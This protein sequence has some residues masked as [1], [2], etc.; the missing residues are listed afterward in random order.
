[1]NSETGFDEQPGIFPRLL[2][3]TAILALAFG[4]Q[5]SRGIYSPDEGY[6]VSIAQAMAQTGD[7][8]IPRLHQVPWLDKPPLSL[9]GIATGLLVF[10]QN[11]WGARASHALC[12]TLTVM[13]VFVLGRTLGTRREGW[14]AATIYATMAIPFTAANVV[15]PDTPLALWTTAA[16]ICFWKTIEPGARH[17]I[18]WKL[19]MCA[20]FGLGFLTKGPAALIPSAT[21]FAFLLVRRQAWSYLLTPWALLCVILFAVLGLG[22]Y[23]Y[24]ARAVPGSLAYFW[25][26]QV[27]GRTI[28]DKY[29]RNAGIKGAI[30]YLP[31]I[32]LGTL[33]WSVAW[34][35]ALWRTRRWFFAR[36]FWRGV[37][38]AD[39][40][41][42]IG[43]WIAV[44]LLILALASSK[45]P[46][47]ALPIFPA[48]ALLTAR[49]I[50]MHLLMENPL[51]LSMRTMG[52]LAVW[53]LVM[54]GLK[55]ASAYYSND[56][57]MRALY[58]NLKHDLPGGPYEIVA[59]DEHLEGLGFYLSALVEQVTT[60]D[61]PYPFFV[62]PEQMSEEVREMHTEPVTH[63]VICKKKKREKELHKALT[64]S[65]V[66]FRE[67]VLPFNRF[68]F[69]CA[70]ATGSIKTG[71]GWQQRATG[72][73]RPGDK[74]TDMGNVEHLK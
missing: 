46:L 17:T 48:L 39:A 70:P 43:L 68:L 5:G 18:S 52:L 2:L 29:A 1:M 47:Y 32:F 22:W 4:F 15:T 33:P 51:G 62:L 69:I 36:A 57:D 65:G 24:L 28:S 34:W 6:Y 44:P 67:R 49:L 27:L 40:S 74:N 3:L 31:V 21:M 64:L 35:L 30:I 56:M 38:E 71:D 8:L 53:C 42:L 11:E 55:A 26:N 63:L 45:L 72:S 58:S 61:D 37:M 54:L 12:Y 50:P 20:A 7:W 16:F 23:A 25:D 41:L 73:G 9:W 60:S 66:T 14:L 19:L 13:L 59:V 10:G